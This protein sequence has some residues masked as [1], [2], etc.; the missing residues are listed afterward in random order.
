MGIQNISRISRNRKLSK[1]LLDQL[2]KNEGR[3][4]FATT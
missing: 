3:V 2:F 4:I 1:A